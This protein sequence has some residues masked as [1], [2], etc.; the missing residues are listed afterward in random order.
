MSDPLNVSM[1]SSSS[2]KLP[3]RSLL[4]IVDGRRVKSDAKCW[5]RV[6]IAEE[7]SLVR[8][9][10]SFEFARRGRLAVRGPGDGG[11]DGGVDMW[12]VMAV[13]TSPR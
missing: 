3:R 6:D 11:F 12:S 7:E 4:R 5:P 2:V 13:C 8:G 1:S 9:R 10:K